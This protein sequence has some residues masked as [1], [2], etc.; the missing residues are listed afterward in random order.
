MSEF[1]IQGRDIVAIQE[2]IYATDKGRLD[3]IGFVIGNYPSI[4]QDFIE[5]GG[6]DRVKDFAIELARTEGNKIMAIKKMRDRFAMGL[7]EAKNEI[8][9][10]W[11]K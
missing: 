10:Q 3:F 8:E 2:E 5:R 9:K 1:T 11:Y 7:V 6:L 4:A